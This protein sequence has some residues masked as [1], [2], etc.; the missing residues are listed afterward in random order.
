MQV[1]E[2]SRKELEMVDGGMIRLR[3]VEMTPIPEPTGGMGYT[4]IMIHYTLTVIE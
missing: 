3:D 4:G 1:E 2:I